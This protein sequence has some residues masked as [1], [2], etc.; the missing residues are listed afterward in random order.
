MCETP[1]Y[2]F[3]AALKRFDRMPD[4]ESLAFEPGPIGR[5]VSPWR[6]PR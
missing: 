1:F 6:R 2:G 4:I 3:A 5:R